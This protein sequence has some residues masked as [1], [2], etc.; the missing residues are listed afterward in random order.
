MYL[1]EFAADNRILFEGDPELRQDLDSAMLDDWSSMLH[2]DGAQ[3][4][5]DDDGVSW[6]LSNN[7]LIFNEKPYAWVLWHSEAPRS[8]KF[9]FGW[10][11]EADMLSNRPSRD[12][13]DTVEARRAFFQNLKPG[14]RV[15]SSL[16]GDM[17]V[18]ACSIRGS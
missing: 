14:M 4:D 13:E 9:V 3:A 1:I 12:V 8:Y 15:R 2:D 18:L 10:R 11:S 7:L 17:V 16:G 5:D 6:V